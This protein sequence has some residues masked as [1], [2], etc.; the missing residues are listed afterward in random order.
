MMERRNT[1]KSDKPNLGL[2]GSSKGP[3]GEAGTSDRGRAGGGGNKK[4]NPE[5]ARLLVEL[6]VNKHTGL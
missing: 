3:N 5:G 2:A 6:G 1:N 4:E